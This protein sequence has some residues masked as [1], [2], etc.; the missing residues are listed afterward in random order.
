MNRKILEAINEYE[1]Q[2]E[3][4]CYFVEYLDSPTTI[5]DDKIGGQP[6]LP[7]G[8]EYPKD[9]EGNPMA[10]LLQV[11]LGNLELANYPK[12]ILEVFITTNMD[13]IFGNMTL[14]DYCYTFRFYQEG[15][16]YQTE[17]PNLN[18]ADFIYTKPLKLAFNKGLTFRPYNLDDSFA[19]NLLLD[20]LESKFNVKLDYPASVR[21]AIG[22]DFY[23]IID[24][25]NEAYV[26][27]SNIGGYPFFI[28]DIDVD[29][30]EG[31][32]CVFYLNNSTRLGFN[33]G[34]DG[35]S[36]YLLVSKEDL[37]LGNFSNAILNII[38]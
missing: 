7:I 13:A 2:T 31:N 3:K 30:H 9:Q 14:P 34:A 4:K 1:D 8:E 15:L 19:N 33:I 17:F 38:Y 11:N 26:P 25:I 27:K 36:F 28:N 10:L 18:I 24:K 29:Y 12:G 21:T 37:K 6:Y 23:E 22:V 32:E 35:G 5:L 16:D 20:L